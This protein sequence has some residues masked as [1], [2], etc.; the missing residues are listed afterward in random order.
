[1]TDEHMAEIEAKAKA[2]IAVFN[3]ERETLIASFRKA[4]TPK[5]QLRALAKIMRQHHA[6]MAGNLFT[7]GWVANMVLQFAE[8]IEDIAED[9]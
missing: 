1:M 3:A 2:E 6:F 7:S 9:L 4:R 8:S 5:A